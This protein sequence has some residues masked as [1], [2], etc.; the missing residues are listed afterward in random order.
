MFRRVHRYQDALR[1]FTKVQLKN[2]D[3]KMV[4]YE[5]GVV[6]QM[7]GNHELAICDFEVALEKDSKFADALFNIGKSRLKNKMVH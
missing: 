5:R 1:Q 3:D 7:M 2:P 4:Y 6:Y